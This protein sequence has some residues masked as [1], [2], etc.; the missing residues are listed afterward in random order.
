[1]KELFRLVVWLQNRWKP[2]FT[3]L[4]IA[5]LAVLAILITETSW[6]FPFWNDNDIW[7][8]F[9]VK[10]LILL[11]LYLLGELS[12]NFFSRF[13]KPFFN[14]VDLE[15]DVLKYNIHV[16]CFNENSSENLLLEE[17]EIH[18][19]TDTLID[20]DI[21]FSSSI[22]KALENAANYF[23]YLPIG[24][25]Q[26]NQELIQETTL[27]VKSLIEVMESNHL[28]NERIRTALSHFH[29]YNIG[30]LNRYCYNF[31]QSIFKENQNSN[32]IDTL[33][34]YQ[35]VHSRKDAQDDKLFS[36]EMSSALKGKGIIIDEENL[37]QITQNAQVMVRIKGNSSDGIRT[38]DK[39]KSS[40]KKLIKTRII[41]I[42]SEID[43]GTTDFPKNFE[44]SK[45]ALNDLLAN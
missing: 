2:V 27:F 44:K 42:G 32:K 22:V 3:R 36:L 14:L 12:Q 30:N 4:I 23:Y 13:S 34:W 19:V 29:V 17:D 6:D 39:F 10:F 35:S 41:T 24:D 38:I 7:K 28:T 20:Y 26:D 18:I 9:G 33:C 45:D 16:T 43:I 8:L 31:S 25:L 37:A 21:P 11:S 15:A 40:L 1:M 5:I